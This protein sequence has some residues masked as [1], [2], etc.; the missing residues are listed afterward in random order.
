MQFAACESTGYSLLTDTY[1]M[2]AC[3][4]MALGLPWPVP[5][6]AHGSHTGNRQ[7]TDR[8]VQPGNFTQ[9]SSLMIGLYARNAHG[10]R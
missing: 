3:Q 6:T 4:P 7:P 2:S 1:Q 5:V 9:G 8:A 10:T